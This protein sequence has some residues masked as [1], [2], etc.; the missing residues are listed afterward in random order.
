MS[1]RPLSTSPASSTTTSPSTS[2]SASHPTS[3]TAL[4]ASK[5]PRTSSSPSPPSSTTN[6]SS[7]TH[8]ATATAATTTMQCLLPPHPP[9]AL[10]SYAAYDVHYAQAHANRCLECGRNLPSA[11]WLELHIA[12]N[13]DPLVGVRRGRGEKVNYDFQIV[14][15]GIDRR[16]SMLRSP[17]QHHRRRRSS[18]AQRAW[19]RGGG[20]KE[21]GGGEGEHGDGV[22]EEEEQEGG[23][24]EEEREEEEDAGDGRPEVVERDDGMDALTT[25][26]EALRF[27]PPSVRFGRG[28][29]RGGLARS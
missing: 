9:L 16:S 1:K 14:N 2:P 22:C 18:A 4:P 27:V 6:P 7:T 5:I 28:K 20:K 21:L 29:R 26:L 15:T 8:P 3:T 13:H 11:W 25:G 24:H 10:P 17:Q 19:G 23:V 12:E